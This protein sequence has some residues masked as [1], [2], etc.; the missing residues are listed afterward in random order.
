MKTLIAVIETKYDEIVITKNGERQY[1]CENIAETL[2]K[3]C[4]RNSAFSY[5]K[6]VKADGSQD[7]RSVNPVCSTK[8]GVSRGYNAG[9][10]FKKNGTCTIEVYEN[11]GITQ[12]LFGKYSFKLASISLPRD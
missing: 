5:Y 11:F 1:I 6:E 12:S 8:H 10:H 4:I 7:L 2:E 3:L 9:D